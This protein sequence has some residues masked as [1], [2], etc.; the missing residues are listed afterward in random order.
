[1]ILNAKVDHDM[2]NGNTGFIIEY[3]L[4]K[5]G[6]LAANPHPQDSRAVQD[7]IY[8]LEIKQERAGRH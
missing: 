6:Y 2:S 1:M 8:A 7:K 3:S 4:G 5:F